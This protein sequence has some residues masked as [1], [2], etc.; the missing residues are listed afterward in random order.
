MAAVT[1][2]YTVPIEG[3]TE[4][5]TKV[6]EYNKEHE[7]IV[8][9]YIK[10][11]NQVDSRFVG[12]QMACSLTVSIGG[13]SAFYRTMSI[14][15]HYVDDIK[16]AVPVAVELPPLPPPPPIQLCS[17]MNAYYHKPETHGGGEGLATWFQT[18]NCQRDRRYMCGLCKDYMIGT[19]VNTEMFVM[20]PFE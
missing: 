15:K 13:L 10:V 6:S 19:S 7:D 4:F 1:F 18:G 9:N 20:H 16:A 5:C 17:Y 8:Y 14:F 11:L 2:I 12:S 3:M